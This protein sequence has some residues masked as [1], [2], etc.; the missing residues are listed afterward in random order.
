MQIFY[1][2]HAKPFINHRHFAYSDCRD[3][4]FL[5]LAG[6]A[7]I[8]ICLYLELELCHDGLHVIFMGFCLQVF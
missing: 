1:P 4:F 8:P 6:Y 3:C 5:S 2:F 7:V